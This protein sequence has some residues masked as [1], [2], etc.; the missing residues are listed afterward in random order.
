[1][2]ATSSLL[3]APQ[4]ARCRGCPP[5]RPGRTRSRRVLPCGWS[6]SGK[7]CS[8]WQGATLCMAAAGRDDTGPPCASASQQA[9]PFQT[10]QRCRRSARVTLWLSLGTS[11]PL[12]C[13]IWSAGILRPARQSPPARSGCSSGAQGVAP[14]L[15]RQPARRSAGVVSRAAHCGP[16]PAGAPELC[17]T[18]WR[19][20]L[21]QNKS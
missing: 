19:D 10:S 1:M 5:P 16:G 11:A 14:H 3:P 9:A 15:G 17:E 20:Q 13:L 21:L 4:A 8:R 18:P 6:T 7:P 2:Q 12:I